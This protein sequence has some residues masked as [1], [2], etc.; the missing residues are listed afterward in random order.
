MPLPL[1]KFYYSLNAISKLRYIESNLTTGFLSNLRLLVFTSITG[2]A[3]T[4]YRSSECKDHA[5]H[6]AGTKNIREK[7]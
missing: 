5:W 4:Q 1:P 3:S 2:N 6:I 7:K